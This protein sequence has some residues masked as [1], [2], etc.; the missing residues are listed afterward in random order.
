VSL[1]LWEL[2]EQGFI[3]FSL[4]VFNGKMYPEDKPKQRKHSF[5]PGLRLPVT[6]RSIVGIIVFDGEKFLL[7][8]RALN[9]SGWEYPKGG[10]EAGEDICAAIARELLEETGIPKFEVVGKV[11]KKKFFDRVRNVVG[12]MESYLIRVSSN[13]KVNFEHQEL[14]GGEMI[15]EHDG[16]KWCFPGEAVKLLKYED[17]KQSMKKAIQML[18][19]SMEK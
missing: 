19:L 15:M 9:W 14:R 6:K 16:F 18:G 10:I 13:N 1:F 7:L 12:V 4:F 3:V 5:K 8:H 17:G 11:D 2:L